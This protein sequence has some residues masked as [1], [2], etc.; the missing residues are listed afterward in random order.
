MK[1]TS[2]CLCAVALSLLSSVAFAGALD[3]PTN[4]DLFFTNSAHKTLKPLPEF[5]KIFMSMPTKTRTA[6]KREC[7]DAAMSKPYAVFCADVNALAGS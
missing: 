6:M 1:L 4:M 5:R 2:I 3:D 7:N